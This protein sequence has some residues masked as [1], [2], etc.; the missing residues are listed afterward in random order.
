MT[1]S[2]VNSVSAGS[3]DTANV[4]TGAIDT[5]GANLL[6]LNVVWSSAV[7]SVTISDSNGNTWFPL[8]AA[9]SAG[10]SHVESQLYYAKN[11]IAGTGHT[12][13]VT[14]SIGGIT[15][16]VAVEAWSGADIA[17]PFDQENGFG[18]NTAGNTIQPGSV[19]PG[20][21]NELLVTG[22]LI[23]A[24][25]SGLAIDSSFAISEQVANGGTNWGCA[26]G[27]KVQTNL[28]AENPTW[29]WTG[30]TP[31][32]TV[33]ATFRAGV[34]FRRTLSDLGTRV[35]SRQMSVG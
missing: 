31:S 8:T 28:G 21:N 24:A 33:I 14:G 35:G 5:T 29:S 4:T 9:D 18:Q 27:H 11:P 30:G 13:T 23:T 12:F 2:F 15:P 25:F 10:G 16:S 34:K 26:I 20:Q 1:Y 22:I 17:S 7:G 19:T 3:S 6:V 32:A